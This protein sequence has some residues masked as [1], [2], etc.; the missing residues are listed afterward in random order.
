MTPDENTTD[1]EYIFRI[2]YCMVYLFFTLALISGISKRSHNYGQ[3]EYDRITPD[4]MTF[5]IIFVV[6]IYSVL[7]YLACSLLVGLIV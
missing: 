2:L 5:T 4:Q 6:G 1:T 7:N 3:E